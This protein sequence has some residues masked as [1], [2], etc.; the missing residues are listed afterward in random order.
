[1]QST[2][3]KE[4]GVALKKSVATINQV[5]SLHYALDSTRVT[6]DNFKDVMT[7]RL[8][9]VNSAATVTGKNCSKGGITTA[10]GIT[11]CLDGTTLYVDVNGNR[12][13]NQETPNTITSESF[14]KGEVKDIY[15]MTFEGTRVVPQG[16]AAKI[17]YEM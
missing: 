3:S 4:F 9:V 11:Y 12:G 1:M 16:A 14:K 7:T 2:E 6:S 15:S 5:V 17:M 10:D 13:P 8:N